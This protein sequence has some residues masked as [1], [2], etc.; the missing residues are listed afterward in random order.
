MS[1]N[2]RRQLNDGIRRFR[3]SLELIHAGDPDGFFNLANDLQEANKSGLVQAAYDLAVSHGI[4]EAFLN[5]GNYLAECGQ[6]KAACTMWKRAFES[7]DERAAVLL[8]QQFVEE[9]DLDSAEIWYQKASAIPESALLHARLKTRLGKHEE[10]LDIL[11]QNSDADAE[12]AVELVLHHGDQ[13]SDGGVRLLEKHHARG[14]LE[15]NIPLAAL[16]ESKGKPEQAIALLEESVS[17]GEGNAL[18]NLG[19]LLLQ[20]GREVEGARW[21][22]KAA[23]SG[24]KR[25]KRILK[26]L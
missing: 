13:F 12:A 26:K 5:Y 16:H 10:A 7:G 1:G 3:E 23:R 19:I 8:A 21:I 15:V 25:A 2:R 14:H 17:A 11:K 9:N 20:N 6:E 18:L 22:K 4:E 24:D